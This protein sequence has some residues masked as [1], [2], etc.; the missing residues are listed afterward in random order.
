MNYKVGIFPE[1]LFLF[2]HFITFFFCSDS[3]QQRDYRHATENDQQ[4]Q[5]ITSHKR[6]I[7]KIIFC[8][9]QRFSSLFFMHE[10]EILCTSLYFFLV[11]TSSRV[12]VRQEILISIFVLHYIHPYM[13]H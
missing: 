4:I 8:I 6:E 1:Y 5:P 11:C 10:M 3:T 2:F 13:L 7:K 9:F 12:R